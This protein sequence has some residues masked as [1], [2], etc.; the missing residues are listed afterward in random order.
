[1]VRA[2][3]GGGGGCGAGG[4]PGQAETAWGP[5]VHHEAPRVRSGGEKG[6][7][8]VRAAFEDGHPKRGTASV[9][10]VYVVDPSGQLRDHFR[11]SLLR[12]DVERLVEDAHAGVGISARGEPVTDQVEV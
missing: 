2:G 9:F 6:S 8:V 11:R 3:S 7:G 10:G 4:G 1:S 12:R 5:A